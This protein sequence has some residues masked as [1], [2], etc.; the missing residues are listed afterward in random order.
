MK[1]PFVQGLLLIATFLFAWWAFSQ[2]NWIEWLNV[3]PVKEKA[4][5]KLGKLIFSTFEKKVVKSK[6][7]NLP[8]DTLKRRICE[9]N[10]ID[11]HSIK[12]YAVNSSEVN[13]FA[14]PYGYIMINLGI[15]N[16]CENEEALAG[17]LAHEIAHVQKNHIKKKLVKE[18]GAAA[19]SNLLLNEAAGELLGEVV[20]VVT[21]RAYDRGLETE[22]D[23]LAAE[24]LCKAG[25]DTKPFAEL[26]KKLEKDA[27]L[28]V[29]KWASTHPDNE[30][31]A[32]Q[33]IH[34][35][36]ACSNSTRKTL[37]EATWEKLKASSEVY[38]SK[39]L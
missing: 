9:A 18:L 35:A 12:V 13:A 22:A 25:L 28:A 39:D 6:S 38:G 33:I 14:L 7:I 1:N 36:E 27:D 24:F 16:E 29:F 30:E 15:I 11:L 17:V 5:E 23:Q 8:L 19:I 10:G 32:A 26:I 2:V 4:D 3:K 20:H 31:R 34:D 37:A 21:S